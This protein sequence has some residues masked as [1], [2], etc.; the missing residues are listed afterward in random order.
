MSFRKIFLLA[1]VALGIAAFFVF[2]LGRFL[3]LEYLKQS[4]ASFEALYASQPLKVSLVY[5]AIYVAATALSF[6]GAAIITLA[7]GAIFGL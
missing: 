3:S 6:P 4:Q 7:G 5:F 1:V 2:D